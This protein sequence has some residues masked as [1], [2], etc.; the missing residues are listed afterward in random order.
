M[1][2]FFGDEQQEPVDSAGLRDFAALVL[3][4]EGLPDDGEM[5]VILV[6]PEQMAEYNHQFMERSGPTD[7]LAFPLLELVPGRVP[8]PVA[9]EPPVA[10]GDVFLCPAEIRRRA[11]AERIDFEDYLYLL[12]AHGI[13]HL[14]GY[15]HHDE[16]TS[17]QMEAREEELLAMVGRWPL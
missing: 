7:V 14:L 9:N 6:E 4:E 2:V 8:A 5:A 13:L 12:L 17:R 15:D 11:E 10:L 1:N 3:Q 16:R